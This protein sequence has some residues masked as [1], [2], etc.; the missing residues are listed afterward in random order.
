MDIRNLY[1]ERST[2]WLRQDAKRSGVKG[3]SKMSKAE[4]AYRAGDRSKVIGKT[5]KGI[6]IV[7]VGTYKKP[8]PDDALR[9]VRNLYGDSTSSQMREEAKRMG[10]GNTAKLRKAE[11]KNIVD[12][13]KRLTV[14]DLS[15]KDLKSLARARDITVGPRM[16]KADLVDALRGVDRAPR[17]EIRTTFVDEV[18]NKSTID[19]S[20]Y[21]SANIDFVWNHAKPVII[22][23]INDAFNRTKKLRVSAE[24]AFSHLERGTIITRFWGTPR[25][26]A[27]PILASTNLDEELN[28]QLANI[29]RKIDEFTNNG[30]G[31]ILER[32]SRFYLEIYRWKPLRGGTYKPTPKA[33]ANKNAIINVNNGGAKTMAVIKRIAKSMDIPFTTKTEKSAL[34]KKIKEIDP[35]ALDDNKCFLWAILSCLYPSSDHVD[36]LS[37]YTP[38]Q[39][40]LN[41]KMLKYPVTIDQIQKFANK[42]KLVINVF[43]WKDGGM[44]IVHTDDR[45]Y[46]DSAKGLP[47][48][49]LILY[50][51]HYMWIK[52]MSALMYAQTEHKK[53]KYTC[54]RCLHHSTCERTFKDHIKGCLA[55]HD[56]TCVVKMPEPGSV[57]KFKNIKNMEKAPYTVYADFESIIDKN[58]KVHTACGYGVNL[59]NSLGESLRFETYRGEDCMERF[60]AELDR[61]EELIYSIPIAK[62]IITPEQERE[63][64][65]ATECYMCGREAT[66]ED[67]LVRDH[68]HV[69]GSYRGPAHNSCNL[70]H[71]QTKK[72]NVIFHNLKGYDSHLIVKAYEGYKGIDVIA[73]TD[74]KYMSMRIDCFKFI[75]SMQHLNSSL[76]KLVEGLDDLPHLKQEFP[77]HYGLLARKG[78]YPYEY[79][80]SHER[81][82]E[83]QLPKIIHFSSSLDNHAGLQPGDYLHAQKV[84]KELGC[85]TLGDYHDLYLKT[86]VLLLTDVFESYRS[87]AMDVYGLDPCHYISAPSLS[88][89]ALLKITKQELELISDVD[90]YNFVESGIRGGV[91]TCGGLRYAKANNPYVEGYDK[92][93]PATYLM[94]LDENNLYGWG[95][96]QKLPTGG[97]EWVKSKGLPD[98]NDDEGYT[99][100]VDLEYPNK[101][102]DE[103]NDYP[104]APE[105][106]KPDQ[107]SEYMRDVGELDKLGEPCYAKVSKLV[108]NLRDKR[109]YIVHH[110]IL[111]YYLKKGLRLTK[112]HRVLKFK[113]SAWM[114][115]YIRLNTDL[116]KKAKTDFKK[117]FFKLMNNA[118]FGKSMEN[119]R[120][121]IDVELTTKMNRKQKLIN[122]PRFKCKKE[123]NENLAAI[124]MSKSTVTLNKPIYVG[125]A[126]LDLSKLLMYEFFY[127]DIRRRY[128][129]A[130][131]MYTDTDSLVLLIET[132][133]FYKEMPLEKYD[134]SNY[135]NDHPCYSEKNKK[136]IGLPKDEGGGKPI[137]EFVALRAKS[138]CVEG[139][140]WG[141]TKC[142]GVKKCI[143][144]NLKFDTYKQCLDSG[145]PVPNAT[146]TT[147]QS[148]LHKIKN[149]TFSK[150]TLSAF[151]DKRYYLDS[152]NS[153][154]H[155]HYRINDINNAAL[156]E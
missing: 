72:I 104:L 22:G 97:F 129:D 154:A 126:I 31:W 28:R 102:H 88:W 149:W 119:V 63:F 49:N 131:M 112:V 19:V 15:M 57:M 114:E 50:K 124:L 75:D 60:F 123:F 116:R 85:E 153:L 79:M 7:V 156:L 148:K 53:S 107:W 48:V 51:N 40:S 121:R 91:S 117:E 90:M 13:K 5:S 17:V 122:K 105:S 55:A 23:R 3:Y 44:E 92:K 77:E 30:S 70:K 71:R 2:S 80:D 101:L 56:G 100:E 29:I 65:T 152:I 130:R 58:T 61:I 12:G 132:E 41:T 66:E 89:Y 125:Q 141:L 94:Y 59:V 133:D 138:Y 135:P 18:T 143:T 147:L 68:D 26:G 118:G 155:G 139:E 145:D 32:V 42:N 47:E 127:D 78:V 115:P 43:E 74:E 93:K 136:V 27:V 99:A 87:T 137:A 96:S 20:S 69:S 33:L 38:Y 98:I 10:F 24:V 9:N 128:P 120:K 67:W 113:E 103:H 11:L 109:K 83:K 14:D 76:A 108:P 150:K 16:K 62:I 35:E 140:G 4:L 86:D 46:T 82:E 146:M 1:G 64:K 6:P 84:W 34:V 151:D 8:H 144:K 110:S 134:T 81:F 21:Q 25:E 39:N 106:M 73:N 54:L 95:M 45:L 37:N 142:K 36:R 111:K 52:S